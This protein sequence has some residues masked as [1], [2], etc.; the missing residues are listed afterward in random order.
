MNLDQLNQR[1]ES[2]KQR[3]SEISS[4]LETTG[5]EVVAEMKSK[6]P[7]D[8]G[9]LKSSISKVVNGNSLLFTMVG[10]GAFVNYG[11]SGTKDNLGKDVE[12]GVSPRPS[13]GGIFKFKKR[14]FGLRSQQFYNMGDIKDKVLEDIKSHIL[15]TDI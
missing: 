6:A 4:V 14:Q 7:S 15:K 3:I 9:K 11:V 13:S 5:N 2:M 10:Y 8:T 1:L 12:F